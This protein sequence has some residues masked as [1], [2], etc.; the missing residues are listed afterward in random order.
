MVVRTTITLPEPLVEE[1]DRVAGARGRSGFLARAARNELKR[2]RLALAL[3]A[4]R[5]ALVGTDAWRSG[6]EILEF[7]DRLR[8]EDR[9]PWTGPPAI[10]RE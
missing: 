4:A 2:T 7:V 1:I 9:D 10:D 3:D 5:G 8:A 6:D